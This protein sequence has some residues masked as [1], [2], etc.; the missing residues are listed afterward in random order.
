MKCEKCFPNAWS[1]EVLVSQNVNI[2][3]PYFFFG[4]TNSLRRTSTLIY[5]EFTVQDIKQR[6]QLFENEL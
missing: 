5:R 4:D 6:I 1:I 3:G 2:V